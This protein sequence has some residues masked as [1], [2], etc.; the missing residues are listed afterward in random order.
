MKLN[1][2][3]HRLSLVAFLCLFFL[4]KTAFSQVSD[5]TVKYRVSYDPQE[6][7]YT[8]WAVPQYNTP[9][10]NNPATEE[11][12][13]T[14][15]VTLRV[16]VAFEILTITDSLGSWDKNPTKLGEQA[17]FGTPGA[18]RYYAIGKAPQ[19]TNYG[20]FTAGD[21]VALFSFTGNAC[22]GAVEIMP[23]DDP[24]VTA[25][26]TA[27]NLHVQSS[28]Y[29]RSGQ[30]AGGNVVPLEQ[31]I[32]V[33]GPPAY[34]P[35]IATDDL[36]SGLAPGSNAVVAILTNDKLSDSAVPLPNQ[37]TV[38]LS[39]EVPSSGPVPGTYS[40][41]EVDGK[42]VMVVTG[43]G[44]W[45]YD[46]STGDLTFDPEDG[47]T[48][49]PTP[50]TYKLTETLSGLW[51]EATVTVEYE[52]VP[53]VAED[54]TNAPDP[55][56]LAQLAKPGDPV[57]LTILSNDVLADSTSA[58]PTLVDVDLD[59]TTV[60]VQ[61]EL[62]VANEGTWAYNPSTGELTFTPAENFTGDPTPIVYELIENYT[63]ESDFATVTVLYNDPPVAVNDKYE[64]DE[65]TELEVSIP[66]IL[67][68]DTDQ[69][70]PAEQLTVEI[71]ESTSNGTVTLNP[72]GSFTYMP[73]LDYTGAD[74]FTYKVYDGVSYSNVATVSITI[75]PVNDTLRLAAKVYLQGALYGVT[76][77]ALMR[78]DL[79]V[80]NL[81]PLASPYA[82]WNP[83][84]GLGD[85]AES[86]PSVAVFDAAD[87]GNDIVDWV[88]VELRNADDSTVVVVSR[89]ALLQRDGDI[90][91]V[92]GTSPVE[93]VMTK[94]ASYYVTIK[95]RNHLAVMSAEAIAFTATPATVDFRQ[96]GTPTFV[97]EKSNAI[98]QSQVDVLQGKAMWAGNS[99]S[100][101]KVGFQGTGNDVE[102]ISTQV[103][104]A[105]TTP[106]LQFPN[107]VLKGYHTGDVNM[108]GEV[109]FQGTSND[110]EFIYQNIIKN[111]PGNVLK[112]N[113]FILQEQLPN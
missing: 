47:F 24:F 112:E 78:D 37:V 94:E 39:V 57:V 51:D 27:Y 63:T 28:F 99:N 105:Q 19:E 32:G 73:K 54:D 52:K 72:D 82:A 43:Q 14:A 10:A 41:T 17:N 35:P 89:S 50:I 74:S 109:I 69:D 77:G 8:V 103:M 33:D 113:N 59:T 2:L 60:E 70:T 44:T 3:R 26:M 107:Y 96:A 85:A 67:A 20:T 11:F 62:V 55:T 64:T 101:G 12:G 95:H 23:V 104:G 21:S 48:V 18:Y 100:D 36:V 68:N 31:Y 80:K 38:S 29:S 22:A 7:L 5:N 98:H 40:S 45:T 81:L 56:V 75:K 65:D 16:P 83:A 111:H 15:Q 1:R 84:Q 42:I 106:D 34:C 46:P 9:N 53:P 61:H 58:L 108:N 93:F 76:E 66:G 6:S 49:N 79:R 71:V 86:V 30:P 90:V 97:K 87:E 110:I 92:D 25:A 88:F 102:T 91:A 13:S 4:T